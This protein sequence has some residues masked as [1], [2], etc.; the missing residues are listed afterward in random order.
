VAPV[1]IAKPILT[2]RLSLS[3]Y[4]QALLISYTFQSPLT[5]P[6]A[7]PLLTIQLLL[8]LSVSPV[9]PVPPDPRRMYPLLSIPPL[10][11][12]LCVPVLVMSSLLLFLFALDSP[13]HLWIAS[14]T[15]FVNKTFVNKS[16]SPTAE[17][18]VRH[19]SLC[20]HTYTHSPALIFFHFQYDFSSF[21]I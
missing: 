14:L 13:R 11:F 10:T 12:P 21:P 1:N 2:C 18:H 7:T 3:P 8:R 9:S 17:H 16:L 6:E 4:S 5:L 20:S 19:S 15:Y